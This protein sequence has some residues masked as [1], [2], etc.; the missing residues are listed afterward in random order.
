MPSYLGP[1][2]QLV[3]FKS[4]KMPAVEP[5]ERSSFRSTMGGGLVEFRAPRGMRTW[6]LSLELAPASQVAQLAALV[7][8]FFGKPPWVFVEASAQVNNLFHPDAAILD[9]GTWDGPGTTQGG[10]GVTADGLMFGR[11]VR[12][13]AGGFALFGYRRKV[14]DYFPVLPGK[15]VTVSYY[16]IGTGAPR[17]DFFTASGVF[18]SAANG[19]TASGTWTRRTITA[20]PPANAAR[21][22]L[23]VA[24]TT[25]HTA[26]LPA[27]TWTAT[28]NP[29]S[30]GEGCN[31]VT[32]DNL[33]KAIQLY[34]GPTGQRASATA[35]VR[36]LN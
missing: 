25:E 19:V 11:S 6:N 8:G 22:E 27:I 32:V 7:D 1:H 3:E 12:I 14:Q 24:A 13:A 36:E 4:P 28:V 35:T 16:G 31:T 5:A 21:G 30:H 18:I 15:P 9:E 26:T 34:T 29:W 33:P 2:G 10:A 23:R 17:I 20:T